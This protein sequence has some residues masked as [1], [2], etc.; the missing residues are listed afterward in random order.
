MKIFRKLQF[1][2]ILLTANGYLVKAQQSASTY[3]N[4][5][6]NKSLPD[7][8]IM[9]AK[10]GYYYLYATENIKNVPISSSNKQIY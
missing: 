1:G 4:P 9:K 3:Q 7:P 10:N 2:L 6:I 8:T 5:V